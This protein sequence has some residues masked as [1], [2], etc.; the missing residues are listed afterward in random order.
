[1]NDVNTADGGLSKAPGDDY[2]F[3]NEVRTFWRQL[4]N[5][6]LFFPLLV[7]WIGIFHFLGNATLGYVETRSLFVWM[8]NAYTKETPEADDGH[9]L[10]IPFVVL[11]LIWWKRDKLVALPL[12]VWWPGLL[13]LVGAWLIHLV[14]YLGQ[15]T[16]T[17]IVAFFVGV[18][19]LM[20]LA[21]GKEFL[22]QT[23]FPFVLFAFMVPL[24]SQ[25]GVVTFPLR[26]LVTKLV[27]FIGQYGLGA[28]VVAVGT[29][30]INPSMQYQYE[31]A[32]PCSG[33]RSLI[34]ISLIAMVYAYVAIRGFWPRVALLAAAVPLAVI[35]NTFRMLLIVLASQLGG[36]PWGNYVHE[37]TIFSLT[38]YV[39]AIFGL[40]WL[41]GKLEKRQSPLGDKTSEPA[42]P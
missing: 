5:K 14:G 42:I 26:I 11:G 28:D 7:V 2:S 1:M 24:G 36:Q 29:Q 18:Y 35:G 33:M 25:T 13:I 15:E 10:I 8:M 41:G 38:P 27:V 34:A 17:C 4:P 6:A 19:G 3:S 39:P 31:I 32:V 12:R 21:W 23:F 9:G 40:I 30:L 16:R 20:G 22:R 37:S